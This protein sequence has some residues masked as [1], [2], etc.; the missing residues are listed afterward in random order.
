MLADG[1]LAMHLSLLSPQASRGSSRP[2]S[3]RPG[4]RSRGGPSRTTIGR[5]LG[6]WGLS[7]AYL[8]ML[9]ITALLA[10]PLGPG[11]QRDRQEKASASG[12]L[13]QGQ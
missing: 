3:S 6:R 11:V 7:T 9:L 4:T 5:S 10:T 12:S 13:R 8:A 2:G 1:T